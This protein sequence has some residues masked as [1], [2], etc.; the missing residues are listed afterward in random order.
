M[1]IIVLEPLSK[2]VREAIYAAEEWYNRQWS[3]SPPLLRLSWVHC[4]AGSVAKHCL[5]C[6]WRRTL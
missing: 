1:V 5:G 4:Q 3:P 2:A 6:L